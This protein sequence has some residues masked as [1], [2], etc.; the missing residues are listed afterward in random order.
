MIQE[1]LNNILLLPSDVPTVSSD[2]A[3][4][5]NLLRAS[6]KMLE[7]MRSDATK[8]LEVVTPSKMA[9]HRRKSLLIQSSSRCHPS[10]L[11]SPFHPNLIGATLCR[12]RRYQ[13]PGVLSVQIDKPTI[14]SIV[15]EVI[16]EH[17]TI[18]RMANK[19]GGLDTRIG[20][21]DTRI[22]GL[23]TRVGRLETDV[24]EL[25]SELKVHARTTNYSINQL[26]NS[27]HK[28]NL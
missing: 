12:L 19:I 25:K 10:P 7:S 23:D 17:P 3:D 24:S 26:H 15:N 21:L 13:S 6:T 9:Y 18:Q 2:T 5:I 28:L 16:D 8:I 11:A 1:L 14:K 22:G 27:G 20:G 4:L